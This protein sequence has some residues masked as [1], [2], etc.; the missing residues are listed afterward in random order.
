MRALQSAIIVGKEVE[1]A[2]LAAF[3]E[4]GI[5]R[6]DSCSPT[7]KC[8]MPSSRRRRRPDIAAAY[9]GAP[10]PMTRSLSCSCC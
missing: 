1:E 5:R 8:A 7:L 9:R 3:D 10:R 2:L 4:S 6:L